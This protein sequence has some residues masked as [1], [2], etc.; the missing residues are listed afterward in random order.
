M[1]IRPTDFTYN[2]LMLNFA[3]SRNQEM[4]QKL[5]QEAVDK[6]GI[7]PSKHRYNNLMVCY[8]K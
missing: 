4:V 7:Q 8:A 1:G 3:R 6:Y 5:N 2:H